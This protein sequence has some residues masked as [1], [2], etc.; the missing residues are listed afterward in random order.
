MDSDSEYESSSEEVTTEEN[1]INIRNK[2]HL[3]EIYFDKINCGSCKNIDK[4]TKE[5]KINKINLIFCLLTLFII[6]TLFILFK[7]HN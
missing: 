4:N 1:N 6:F 7:K 3:S 5:N 2:L